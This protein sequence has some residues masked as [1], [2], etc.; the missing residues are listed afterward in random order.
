MIAIMSDSQYNNI[1]PRLPSGLI[2]GTPITSTDGRK[3]ICHAFDEQDTAF[4]QAEGAVLTDRLPDDWQYQ[5]D[6]H[7]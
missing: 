6:T 4:L 7:G 3:A 5:E 2:V 1:I